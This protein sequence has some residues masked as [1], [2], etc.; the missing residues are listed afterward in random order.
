MDVLMPEVIRVRFAPSPTGPLHIGGARTALFNYV[1]ARKSGGRFI[2]RIDDTDPERSNRK[3][4]EDIRSGLDWLGIEWDEGPDIGGGC[5]PYRQSERLARYAA[6]GRRL[7]E[8]GAAFLDQGGALR[9]R[10]PAEP[11]VVHDLICG[12]C[13]FGPEALGPEPV[14]ARSDGSPTYHLASVVDDIDMC[15]SHVIRGQDHLTNTAKHQLL[16]SALGAELPQFAHLPLILNEEG[17]KLSKRSSEGLVA[18]SEFRTRGYLPEAIVNF[19]ALLGWSHPQAKEQFTLLEI[20]DAF[21]IERV[22]KTGSIFDSAKLNW[23][24]G[25][26]LR[27]LPLERVTASSLPFTGELE[28]LVRSK[29]I[30]WWTAALD[31]LRDGMAFLTDAQSIAA[32]LLNF[33][34]PFSENARTRIE[35]DRSAVE[36]VSRTLLE[37]LSELP[38]AEECYSPEQVSQLLGRLKKTVALEKKTLFQALRIC[39]MSDTSGPELKV[40]LP[41]LSREILISRVQAVRA[42]L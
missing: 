29:G 2:L 40:L 33:E 13:V 34:L 7:I 32:L 30:K 26:Y 12:D 35:T 17:G 21:Q 8:R 1:F 27:S 18:L 14:L 19:L 25:Y 3:F 23:L 24:N 4:E 38:S 20:I 22:G 6:E 11:I 15:I 41:L 36:Q 31:A 10:Y 28:P 37:L 42:K 39:V 5:G 9:L 16:F